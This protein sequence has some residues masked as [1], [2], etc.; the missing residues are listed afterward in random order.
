MPAALPMAADGEA[1]TYVFELQG[2]SPAS[3]MVVD[4]FLLALL[5][6]PDGRPVAVGTWPGGTTTDAD[7]GP[8]VGGF[9]DLIIGLSPA[10]V[11]SLPDKYVAAAPEDSAL[12]TLSTVLIR[13]SEAPRAS[14]AVVH[15]AL[16]A[17]LA[18]GAAA[19][20]GGAAA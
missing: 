19:G 14:T 7:S 10:L 11:P 13:V 20:P 2:L 6:E 3:E 8:A 12:P 5:P 15:I 16:A 1:F 4:S 18:A 9:S 17:L